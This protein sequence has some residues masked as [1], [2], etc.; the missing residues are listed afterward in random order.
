MIA[1]GDIESLNHWL[2]QGKL[3]DLVRL[4]QSSQKRQNG[5]NTNDFCEGGRHNQDGE[6]EKLLFSPWANVLPKID[7]RARNGFR[8]LQWVISLNL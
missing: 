7:Q 3:K 4:S 5:A 1:I 8:G 2:D 6:Q